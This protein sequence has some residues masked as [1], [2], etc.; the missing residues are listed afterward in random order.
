MWTDDAAD[1][2]AEQVE[3]GDEF[4][5]IHDQT[6]G[7]HWLYT[8]HNSFVQKDLVNVTGHWRSPDSGCW[9]EE[10]NQR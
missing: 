9:Q 2:L 3:D 1:F 8:M 5:L 6:L 4:L 10:L 7:M